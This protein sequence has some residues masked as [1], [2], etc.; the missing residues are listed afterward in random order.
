MTFIFSL[1]AVLTVRR[2]RED[3]EERRLAAIARET[4]DTRRD[5]ARVR[6]ELKTASAHPSFNVP[7]LLQGVALHQGYARIALLRQALLEGEASLAQ[8]EA[9][10]QTQHAVYLAARQARELLED[11][12]A[13]QRTAFAAGILRREQRG[14][15]DLFLARRRRG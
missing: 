1:A 3:A 14:N 11:L 5:L 6:T 2:Q 8:Q 13:R 15:D 12:E 10:L 4:E 9:R 7:Q